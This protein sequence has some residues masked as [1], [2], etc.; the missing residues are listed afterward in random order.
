MFVDFNFICFLGNIN[1]QMNRYLEPIVVDVMNKNSLENLKINFN[2]KQVKYYS[3]EKISKEK[4][5]YKCPQKNCQKMKIK[6]IFN[7]K[8]N[9]NNLKNSNIN[10]D[11][12][13]KKNYYSRRKKKICFVYKFPNFSSS[14][15][16][17]VKRFYYPKEAFYKSK[18]KNK[19]KCQKNN[20]KKCK[21][22]HKIKN[23]RLNNSKFLNIY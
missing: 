6:S 10:F 9:E 16:S 1:R 3:T 22:C 14:D 20:S 11:K 4:K 8:K 21:I 18:Y 2:E 17:I 5:P 15:I 13:I 19:I 12:F 23:R 7:S